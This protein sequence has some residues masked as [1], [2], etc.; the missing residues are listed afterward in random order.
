MQLPILWHTTLKIFKAYSLMLCRNLT[1]LPINGDTA[2]RNF[3]F[4]NAMLAERTLR[5]F[6]FSH[7]L[8]KLKSCDVLRNVEKKIFF[9]SCVSMKVHGKIGGSDGQKVRSQR[10]CRGL[11]G[12][13]LVNLRCGRV[14]KVWMLGFLFAYACVCREADDHCCG[15]HYWS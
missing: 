11:G 9:C 15:G 2:L 7:D 14:E 8:I 6:S 13:E 10:S 1:W 5:M 4:E 12:V 3:C